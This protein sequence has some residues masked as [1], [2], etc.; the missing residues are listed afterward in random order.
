M[1]DYIQIYTTTDTIDIAQAISN[2]LVEERLAACAQVL[3]P[4]TSTYWWQGKIETSQEWLCIIKS[5]KSL[6][7]QI[8][9]TIKSIHH[10]D[11]P[12]IIAVPITMGSKDYFNWLKKEIKY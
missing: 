5:K 7:K 8:E 12:E 9:D 3:G 1:E 6:Y 10:Y 11:V 4:I 2:K